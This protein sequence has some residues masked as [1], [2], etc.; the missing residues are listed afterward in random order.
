MFKPVPIQIVSMLGCAIGAATLR[1]GRSSLRIRLGGIA[2]D[3]RLTRLILT[4]TALAF[5]I[6]VSI[7]ASHLHITADEDRDCAVCAA[8]AGKVEGPVAPIAVIAPAIAVFVARAWLPRSQI[9]NRTPI[10]LPPSCG[11]P[12][13]A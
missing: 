1:K 3:P 13:I 6:L 9:A 12:D 4:I 5:A 2:F 8:F 7:A 10:L 11:P